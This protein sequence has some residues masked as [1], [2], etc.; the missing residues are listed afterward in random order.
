MALGDSWSYFPSSLVTGEPSHADESKSDEENRFMRLEYNRQKDDLSR[1]PN[2]VLGSTPPW[3]G[4]NCV[5]M[6]NV[7]TMADVAPG[8][9]A[10]LTTPC[11]F[12]TLAVGGAYVLG[13]S[14]PRASPS[15]R[16]A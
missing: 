15:P 4:S 8:T 3:S 14:R 12:G 7:G 11:P 6:T 5:S 2:V 1:D 13:D 9:N 10:T 16:S